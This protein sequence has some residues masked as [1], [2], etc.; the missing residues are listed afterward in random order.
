MLVYFGIG[1]RENYNGNFENNGRDIWCE[2]ATKLRSN[3]NKSTVNKRVLP[4]HYLGVI[5]TLR[6][7]ILIVLWR[8]RQLETCD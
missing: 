4:K 7:I 6:K 8:T 5:F 1:E 3:F 2:I